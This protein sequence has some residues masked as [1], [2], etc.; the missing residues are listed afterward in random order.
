MFDVC[1]GQ[2]TFTRESDSTPHTE[3]V[4]IEFYPGCHPG[5][6][7]PVGC[8]CSE[9]HEPYLNIRYS[10]AT[11]GI[12]MGWD[13]PTS[14]GRPKVTDTGYPSGTPVT[15]AAADIETSAARA[16]CT[17]SAFDDVGGLVSLNQVG[18][19][20]VLY[21]EGNLDSTGNM[22][23]FG[24][25]VL[26]GIADPKG[27]PTVWYDDRLVHGGWPPKGVDFPRVMITSEQIQ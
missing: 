12:S 5:N 3:W 22:D 19:E 9:P 16:N 11:L 10:A 23:Y 18:C 20:C 13:P 1:L 24:S 26:G 2:R 21:N 4:P 14:A 27:T 17:T 25:I 15:C 7:T 6:N 8:N